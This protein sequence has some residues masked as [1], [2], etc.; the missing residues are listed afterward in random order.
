MKVWRKGRVWIRV[1]GW[2]CEG[3]M[4]VK[5]CFELGLMMMWRVNGMMEREEVF[6]GEFVDG[7]QFEVL[8]WIGFNG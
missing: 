2:R 8:I 7:F 4:E 6:E 3:G 5:E 1:T